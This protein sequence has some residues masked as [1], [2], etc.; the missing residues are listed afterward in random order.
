MSAHK[1][2]DPFEPLAID[3]TGMNFLYIFLSAAFLSG[4]VS[5]P[6]V[7]KSASN[8]I[9]RSNTLAKDFA[10]SEG[11]INPE[12]ASALGYRE[13][14]AKAT[15]FAADSESPYLS[16]FQAWELKV[17]NLLSTETDTELVT[18]LRIL[19]NKVQ[20]GRQGVET[21]QRFGDVSFVPVSKLVFLNLR[22][23]INE[24][25]G[26]D[27]QHA[28]LERFS[29][30]VQPQTPCLTIAEYGRESILYQEKRAPK[31]IRL[32]SLRREVE[33]YLDQSS[34]FVDGVRQLLESS[35]EKGWQ[36]HFDV[37]KKQVAKHDR[38]LK[39]Y[40]L[41]K[42]RKDYRL[43]KPM[44]ALIL[45]IRGIS[46]SPEHLVKKGREDYV[47]VMSEFKTLSE[48]V[49]A[50][51]GL[52]DSSPKSVMTSLKKHLLV[53][54]DELEAT[55]QLTNSKLTNI[56]RKNSIVS[57]PE[58]PLKIRLA[59]EAESKA[60]PVPRLEPPP[61]VD[62][63]G[64]RPEFVIPTSPNGI[65]PFDDFSYR[66]AAAALLAH[67][68][69]PGH[70]LQFSAMLDRGVSYIRALYAFNNVNVE[71]WALH[72]EDLMYPYVSDE[73][74]LVFLQFRLWRI[75]RMFLDPEIQLGISTPDDVRKLFV[76]EL[77]V[78]PVMADL[79][80]RRYTFDD[81]GQAPS[82][83]FGLL[84][85]RE[86]ERAARSLLKDD[87]NLKCFNDF[88]LNQG[89]LPLDDIL[90]RVQTLKCGS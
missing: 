4:C 87:F 28:A 30:Y 9:A 77:G 83:Y 71:G 51:L 62:N 78:S 25:S 60:K 36:A 37:F 38:F 1:L 84:K 65:P 64:E 88:V 43:P 55:Y 5:T 58:Q 11:A 75:A 66:E 53:K 27:R 24:Q 52:K 17:Q 41:P 12:A 89:L 46:D 10:Q 48:K 69:R 32:Y 19:L 63:R 57:L 82:Y 16:F 50:R 74:K 22:A 35:G 29:A 33:I 15:C 13:F 8:W 39:S 18:D 67:E 76:D 72:A 73:E 81:V 61:L 68:G 34:Q 90:N 56:I 49:A 47:A 26:A 3:L 31:G 80:A 44:Y 79:E 23:L 70:D 85:M 42:T 14:D 20:V 2:L 59:G 54:P 7:S 86:I 40:F 45:R 21:N 6:V